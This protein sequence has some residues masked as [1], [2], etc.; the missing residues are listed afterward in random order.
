MIVKLAMRVSQFSPEYQKCCTGEAANRIRQ[1]VIPTRITARKIDLMPLIQNA[2]QQ[3]I[4]NYNDQSTRPLQPAC[5]SDTT[6]KN[7]EGCSMNKF[8]QR[9]GSGLISTG[10]ALQKNRFK[11]I[12]STSIAAAIYL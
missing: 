8:I 5:Q 9:V 11:T 1:Q 3:C 7:G 2:N 6:G 12:T 10:C 4:R